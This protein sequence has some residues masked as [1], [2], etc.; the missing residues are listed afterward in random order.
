MIP[1]MK[2]IGHVLMISKH[3]NR[4]EKNVTALREL[5]V[6]DHF[7]RAVEVGNAARNKFYRVV[8]AQQLEVIAAHCALHIA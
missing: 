3:A 7:S 5:I 1:T 8:P 4:A 2:V 6:L